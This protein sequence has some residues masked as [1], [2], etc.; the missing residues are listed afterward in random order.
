[1]LNHGSQVFIAPHLDLSRAPYAL[2]GVKLPS[3][4]AGVELP[5][6]MSNIAMIAGGRRC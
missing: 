6:K 4:V 2:Y 5:R 3:W 1:M